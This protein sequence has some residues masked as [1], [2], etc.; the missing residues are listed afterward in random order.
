MSSQII[1]DV[2]PYIMTLDQY[3]INYQRDNHEND[4]VPQSNS[5]LNE[6]GNWMLDLKIVEE[7]HVILKDRHCP[8]CKK[9]LIKNGMNNKVDYLKDTTQKYYLRYQR[10]VC[11]DHGEIHI[12]YS[13]IS[14]NYPKYPT[15]LQQGVGLVFSIGSPPTKIQKICI[16][17]RS[18]LIPLSTIKSW[19][20][21]LKTQLKPVLYPQKM[22]CS[23][24]LAYD[25]I[26]LKLEGNKGYLL[27]SIDNYTRLV[28]R[29][30]YSA[31]LDKKAV[32]SHFKQIKLHQKVK[33]NS[34]VHDGA[35]VYGSVFKDRSL[36]KIKEGRC[37]THFKKNIRSKLYAAAGLGK[38]LKKPLPRGHFR[39]LR[40]LYWTINSKTEFD[41]IIRLEA[42]RSLAD[43]LKN[44]K[45][46]PIIN[47][48]GSAQEFLQ[49]YLHQP[50]LA[51]TTN[52]IE[53]LHNEIEVY[54]VFKVGQ[55][56]E[57]GIEFVANC[58]ILIHNMRELCRITPKLDKNHTY[59]DNLQETFGYCEGVRSMKNKFARFKTK[60]YRYQEELEGYWNDHYP[61]E[62]LDLFKKLWGHYH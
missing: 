53:S 52:A 32:K 54:R 38:Q 47:W 45:L 14:K 15:E 49:N 50:F 6:N 3:T 59:L 41:Y 43:T 60:I 16:A 18:V 48:V 61:K 1:E 56:T 39:L 8:T 12:D 58:R 55:K 34:V 19:I 44:E 23:G 37:H 9:W 36:K 28:V 27:S 24:S 29:S 21:P 22:P 26:H 57:M 4:S 17:L 11:P 10:Y 62:S 20:Y 7:N 25:E 33:I 46:L 2:R 35:T 31:I 5:L 51:K 30:E 42:S 13:K 40:M